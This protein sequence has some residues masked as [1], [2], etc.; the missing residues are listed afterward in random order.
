VS[1]A[2]DGRE[3]V[4]FADGED[5]LEVMLAVNQLEFSPLIYVERPENCVA[6]KFAFGPEEFFRF[7][8]EQIEVSQ[9][10]GCGGGE[11]FAAEWVL[12]WSRRNHCRGFASVWEVAETDEGVLAQVLRDAGFCAGGSSLGETGIQSQLGAGVAEQKML[13]N[14]LDCP[15]MWARGWLKLCLS[16]VES[17]EGEGD[18]ALKAMEGGV[19]KAGSRYTGCGR[20][21]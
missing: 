4:G 11:R 10:F 13:H 19:H 14:L 16:G 2:L 5:L 17:V 7:G 8:A 9:M 3:A 21:G 1:F 18:L 6:G 12:G 15:L 20:G